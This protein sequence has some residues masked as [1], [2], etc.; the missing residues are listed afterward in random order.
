[1]CLCSCARHDDG[2]KFEEE[3]EVRWRRF[4]TSFVMEG[5]DLQSG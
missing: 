4:Y 3:V 5:R 2:E 1:M